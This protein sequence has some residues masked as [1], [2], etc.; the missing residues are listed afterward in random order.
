MRS[1]SLSISIACASAVALTSV[2]L[3]PGFASAAELEEIIVTARKQE[4][5]LQDVPISIQAIGGEQIAEQGIVDLQQ[6]APYTPNFSYLRAAGASDL[7]FMRG[8]GTFG[9]GI[10]FEPSVGQVF[11]GFFSTRSRLGRSALIDVAQVEVLKGPQGAI[12]GKNT[13]LGAINIVSNKPTEDFEA[14]LSTQYNFEA[15]EGF[16]VEGMISGPFSDR[17]RGRAVI[18]YRD[19]DGWVDNTVTGDALQVSEDLTARFML[20]YDFSET[21]S[22]ELMY[23]RTDFERQGKGRVIAGCLEYQPPAGPPHSIPRAESL[24]FNCGGVTDS[25]STADL[26][27]A[28]PAGALFNSREPFTIESDLI[29]LTLTADFD[30]ITLTSLTSYNDYNINDTFSGDQLDAE[31]VSIE[32]TEQYKQFYQEFRLNGSTESGRLDYIAGL[33]FFSGELDATQSFH[34]IAAAIGPPVPAINPAVSRN[35]FQSSETDSQAVFG[36]VD[37]H[38]NDQFTLSVGG[39]VTNEE[40]DGSK[41]QIVGEVYT[42]DLNNAPVGCN[43]PTVPLSACTMGNDGMTPG[44]AITGNIDDTNFSYNVALQYSLDENNNFYIS[45]ATGFKSGGFDLRGAGNPASF[46]F[47]EEESTNYEIGG[48]HTLAND[49]LRFNWTI[50]HTEVDDLQVSANDPVLIQQI[51]APAD[52]TSEGVEVEL[53]W[54]TPVEGLTVNLAAAYTDATY[55]DFIGSCYLSQPE[56]GTGCFNVGISAGQRAGVQDLKGKQLPVAPEWSSVLGADYRMSVG[57]DLELALSAK[58]LYSDRQFMSIERDPLGVQ[59]ATDRIDASIILSSYSGDH[60]WSLALIGRN[61]TDE[62]V[63]TFV[64][65]STLSGSA[66][67]TTNIEETRSI[68]L[69]ATVG[70]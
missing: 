18:N 22:A 14:N 51:V 61:L 12:I 16:E 56:T 36:Q 10:H 62:L 19:T 55:D 39:R 60:P 33:M 32:N 34:A 42:S 53:L 35:E 57:A 66:V 58:Y 52:V 15:S 2:L 26:R 43:T 23:Q 41:A 44:G 65:A 3:P 21:V 70:F 50:Y 38:M 17:A 48:R 30:S 37:I 54:A 40:R 8:L 68:A 46:I 6:L 28:T 69:R 64:N 47:G 25:N 67:L 5:S 49:S 29:G 20:D 59:E 45:T 9:S 24:G 4:E 31:R 1:L 63:H 7:Y 13:S 11:N 27:R